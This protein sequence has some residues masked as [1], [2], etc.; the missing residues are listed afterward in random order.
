MAYLLIKRGKFLEGVSYAT[1]IGHSFTWTH[2]ESQARRFADGEP[3]DLYANL[4]GGRWEHRQNNRKELR[5]IAKERREYQ[6]RDWRSK[7][8]HDKINARA[9]V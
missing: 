2:D 9:S 1:G 3:A 8:V 4:T 7:S 5:A 6:E